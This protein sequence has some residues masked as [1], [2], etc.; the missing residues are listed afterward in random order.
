M[1]QNRD[2]M[3]NTVSS[4]LL[5]GIRAR[6]HSADFT[7]AIFRTS[8]NFLISSFRVSPQFSRIPPAALTRKETCCAL[9]LLASGFLMQILCRKLLIN[10]NHNEKYLRLCCGDKVVATFEVF[11]GGTERKVVLGMLMSRLEIK[12]DYL[13]SFGVQR[14]LPWHGR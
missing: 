12:M 7:T 13:Q 1:K 9:F 4:K 14:D 10:I 11:R 5:I 2:G 8:I 6:Q 3:R